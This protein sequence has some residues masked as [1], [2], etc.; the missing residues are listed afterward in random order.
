[1]TTDEIA[2]AL[3]DVIA[4]GA[5]NGSKLAFVHYE[6]STTDPTT[7][8]I[9]VNTDRFC[10]GNKEG[11][12]FTIKIAPDNRHVPPYRWAIKATNRYTDK[13]VFFDTGSYDPAVAIEVRDEIKAVL[14]AGMAKGSEP[15]FKDVTIIKAKTPW[16]ITKQPTPVIWTD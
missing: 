1:M 7:I 11:E 12:R 6:V 15:M 13:Q 3:T 10:H 9:T 16:D 14:P 5:E 8:H 4:F 2:E